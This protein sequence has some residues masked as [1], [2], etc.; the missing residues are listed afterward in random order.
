MYQFTFMPIL[1]PSCVLNIVVNSAFPFFQKGFVHAAFS[2]GNQCHSN[3]SFKHV[4]KHLS[5]NL[6]GYN[7]FAQK[8]VIVAAGQSS[9]WPRLS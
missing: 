6:L 1:N 7:P 5:V 2:G 9:R 8:N 3:S 4:L